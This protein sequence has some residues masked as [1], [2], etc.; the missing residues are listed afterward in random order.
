MFIFIGNDEVLQTDKI[1]SILDA[2]LLSSSK[3]VKH[4][5]K[6]KT[7]TKEVRGNQVEA[8]SIIITDTAI[9]YSPLSILTLKKREELYSTIDQ[10]ESY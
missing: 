5:M 3:R 1:I 8:K 2:Q 10:L 9:Y 7:V 6:Y 4:L